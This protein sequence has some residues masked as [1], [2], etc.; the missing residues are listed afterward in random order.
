MLGEV[1]QSDRL[2]LLSVQGNL[3]GNIVAIFLLF[4]HTSHDHQD[5]RDIWFTNNNYMYHSLTKYVW[6]ECMN[7]KKKR[8]CFDCFV[9]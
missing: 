5:C 1:T 7:L 2:F 8:N 9:I 6:C 4:S 3:P